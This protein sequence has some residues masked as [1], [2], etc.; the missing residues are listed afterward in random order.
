MKHTLGPN[1][2]IRYLFLGPK[3]AS[4]IRSQVSDRPVIQSYFVI[5]WPILRL[6]PNGSLAASKKI[7]K[8]LW[9]A[10]EPS[11]PSQIDPQL[12]TDV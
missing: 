3:S 1:L 11:L 4:T 12:M 9:A 2:H 7:R 5:S 8:L 10:L 6:Y